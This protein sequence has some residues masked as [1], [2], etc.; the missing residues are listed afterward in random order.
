MEVSEMAL[1]VLG[2]K[3]QVT[4]PRSIREKMHLNGGDP[5]LLDVAE[6]GSIVLRPAGV[7]PV[8]VYTEKRLREFVQ[9]NRLT[10]GERRRVHRALHGR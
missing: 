10:L 9:E 2:P 3:G 8:E 5:L 1:V 4:I 7:Y 6:D